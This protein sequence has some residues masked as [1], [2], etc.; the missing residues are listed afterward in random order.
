MSFILEAL[1]KSEQAR[2]Q[3]ASAQPFSLLPGIDEKVAVRRYWPYL[4]AAALL[5]N[6]A[7]LFVWLRPAPA[8]DPLAIKGS[9]VTRL[10]QLP[11]EKSADILP[12]IPREKPA[13]VAVRSVP[14]VGSSQS[15]AEP[16]STVPLTR[17]PAPA[18]TAQAPR[19]IAKQSKPVA[20]QPA[21]QRAR[22]AAAPPVE[23]AVATAAKPVAA[24]T[25]APQPEP[26][27]PGVMP[28]LLQKELPALSITGIIRDQSSGGMAI[29]NDKMLREGDE[30]AP[31]LKLE[32][33][34]DNALVFS[35]KGYRF[36][37]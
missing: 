30:V 13:A 33:I 11:V 31:G 9:S 3:N 23:A 34:E 29:V 36:T 35:Y 17:V 26:G 8:G 1:R 21:E 12:V 15:R 22:E 27:G 14:D 2:Q 10:P 6:A 32:K 7:V 25:L 37:R 28:L 20:V 5:V 19:E 24:A 4:L 18:P 16:A